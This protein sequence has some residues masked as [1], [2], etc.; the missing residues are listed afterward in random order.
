MG[1]QELSCCLPVVQEFCECGP[2]MTEAEYHTPLQ[3]VVARSYFRD[4]LVGLEYLH[5][6]RI[7]HRDIKPSNI[8]VAGDGRACIGDFGVSLLLKRDGEM[9]SDVA[10][11]LVL[12]TTHAS[13]ATQ[14]AA[15]CIICSREPH[16]V[17]RRNTGF[18]GTG[19]L[20]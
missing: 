16:L 17:I 3:D 12:R 7:V 4:V 13:N 6:Q 20:R 9:L 19:A 15:L 2:V 18:Y 1:Y 11:E 5:F 14:R 10:G 8:L